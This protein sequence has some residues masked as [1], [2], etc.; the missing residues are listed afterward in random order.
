LNIYALIAIGYAEIG[1]CCSISVRI[2]DVVCVLLKYI[3][4]AYGYMAANHW[5]WL[6]IG[7][8]FANIRSTSAA[9]GRVHVGAM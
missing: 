4:I 7:N 2:S 9:T 3:I 6:Q 8:F 5:W 1:I